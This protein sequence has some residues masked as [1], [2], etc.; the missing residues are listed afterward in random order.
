MLAVVFP[1]FFL[2]NHNGGPNCCQIGQAR[3][4]FH[5][6]SGNLKQFTLLCGHFVLYSG[7]F[8]FRLLGWQHVAYR[9]VCFQGQR[10]Q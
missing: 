6:A 10:V 7:S 2:L 4:A 8:V 3:A 1:F 5:A 9:H